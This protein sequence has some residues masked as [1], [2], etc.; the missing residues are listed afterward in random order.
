MDQPGPGA[1][2]ALQGR[3]RPGRLRARRLGY[4]DRNHRRRQRVH[5]Q[6]VRA[7]P[8]D[9]LFPDSGHVHG[10]LCRRGP[11]PEPAG[12][13]LPE[14]LRL[15]LRSAAGQPAGLGRTDRRAGIGR[16]VQLD[17]PHGVGLQ[18]APDPHARRALLYRSPLQGH[19]DRGRVQRLRRNGQ[20]RRHLAGAQAGHRRRAGHGHGPRDP[21]GI[22]PVGRVDLFPPVRAP[23]HRHAHAGAAERARRLLRARPFPAR[24]APGRR[25]GRTEQPRLE[26]AGAGRGERRPRGAQRQH[27]L[28]LGRRRGQRRREG[29]PLE[30]GIQ[31]RRQRPRDRARADA[32]GQ[33]RRRGRRGLPV[34]RQ[35]ARRTAGAQRA[36][37]PLAPGRRQRG[38]GGHGVRPADGQ[39]RPGPRPGRR[40]CRQLL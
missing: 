8:P 31:G 33:V 35:R 34:L 30:P 21:E 13:R 12:R 39:L 40:Q 22:P 5:D 16:L 3:A 36:G 18:R 15:V 38:P 2:Q 17:L 23:L 19:Q 29:G 9:R 20:V 26:D 28:P 25:P 32:A 6:E 27:R 10:Q 7:R 11:L 37:P 24:L 14:L 4:G 1:R